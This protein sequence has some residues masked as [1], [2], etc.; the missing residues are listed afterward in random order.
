MIF[1]LF[2]FF[3]PSLLRKFKAQFQENPDPNFAWFYYYNGK[4]HN[5][6]EKDFQAYRRYF[7]QSVYWAI[8]WFFLGVVLLIYVY[9]N[10]LPFPSSI[11]NYLY[12]GIGLGVYFGAV[13]SVKGAFL[14]AMDSELWT[15]NLSDKFGPRPKIELENPAKTWWKY[16]KQMFKYFGF[17][18]SALT[19]VKIFVEG[20]TPANRIPFVVSVVMLAFIIIWV[21]VELVIDQKKE[22]QRKALLLKEREGERRWEA[23]QR[24]LDAKINPAKSKKKQ[25]IALEKQGKVK[26]KKY[27]GETSNE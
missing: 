21:F 4:D 16:N 12:I 15:T 11:V 9:V 25:R 6:T 26:L 18:L 8:L 23:Y 13:S 17:Y 10:P 3:I 7:L 27:K 22:H 2:P 19:A 1:Y 14:K 20:V 24:E 5:A